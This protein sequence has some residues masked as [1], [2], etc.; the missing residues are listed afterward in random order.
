MKRPDMTCGNVMGVIGPAVSYSYKNILS[1]GRL[2]VS[3]SNVGGSV[4]SALVQSQASR[5]NNTLE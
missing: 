4:K 2:I 3:C 1:N 5:V